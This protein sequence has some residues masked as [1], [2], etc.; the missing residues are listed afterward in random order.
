MQKLPPAEALVEWMRL[1]LH[2]ATHAWERRADFAWFI[3]LPRPRWFKRA[4]VLEEAQD[5][6]HRFYKATYAEQVGKFAQTHYC[7]A[8]GRKLAQVFAMYRN[9]S[10]E[11]DAW[12]IE[13][14]VRNALLARIVPADQRNPL[15]LT[16]MN[17][18]FPRP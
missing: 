9:L 10:E 2:V 4:T 15:Q 14:A 17:P 18:I 7:D 5:W 16:R 3:S 6:M 1:P 11:I 12:G 8:S 13:E